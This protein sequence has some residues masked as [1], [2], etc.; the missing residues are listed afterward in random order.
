MFKEDV[1]KNIYISWY[2]TICTLSNEYTKGLK[3][4]TKEEIG[5]LIWLLHEELKQRP[6]SSN[7]EP[8]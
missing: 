1:T 6:K 2:E 3:E 4:F 8:Y 7:L 5:H